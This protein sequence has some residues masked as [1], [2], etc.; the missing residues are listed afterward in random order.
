MFVTWTAFMDFERQSLLVNQEGS[1]TKT[2]GS[3]GFCTKIFV[4]I[5]SILLFIA[6]PIFFSI[7]KLETTAVENLI[8]PVDRLFNATR[9]QTTSSFY[10][11]D[12]PDIKSFAYDLGGTTCA[13]QLQWDSTQYWQRFFYGF[14]YISAHTVGSFFVFLFLRR[15]LWVVAW[16]VLNE[17]REELS[18]GIIDKWA[19]FD[20]PF[21]LEPRYDSITSDLV[22][23]IVP[24]CILCAHVVSVLEIRDSIPLDLDYNWKS[25]ASILIPLLQTWLATSICDV[26]NVFGNSYFKVVFI[27]FR[28]GKLIV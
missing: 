12:R 11:Q 15:F 20:S 2:D 16:Y 21:D 5:L 3:Q 10:I 8:D 26:F 28:T 25:M 27:T 24:S 17:V 7:T 6:I 23:A 1:A 22:F 14:R 13:C 4:L 9:V 18:L 19:F